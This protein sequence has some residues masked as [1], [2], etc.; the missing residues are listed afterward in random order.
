MSAELEAL[1]KRLEAVAEKL[2]KAGVAVPAG[3]DEETEE[4]PEIIAYDQ[5]FKPKVQQMEA[6]AKAIDPEV[7]EMT[8]F[9]ADCFTEVRRII[10]TGSRFNKPD[11]LSVVMKP[12][13]DVKNAGAKWI[14]DHY[15]TKFVNHSKAVNEGLTV[16]DWVA[17]GPSAGTFVTEMTGA[18][19]CY[20]NKIAM[21]FRGKDENQ[22]KWVQGFV[23]ALKAFPEYINDYHKNGLKWNARAAKA[24]APANM[25][26]AAPAAAPAAKPAPAQAAKPAAAPAKGG[27]AAKFGGLKIP[28]KAPAKEP[29]CCLARDGLYT[30]EYFDGKNP[31]LP[32]DVT[33]K[34][35][36]NF[37]QCKNC[38]LSVP[39]KVKGVAFQNCEKVTII[40]NDVIGT[41]EITNCK[42]TNVFANGICKTI[43]IDK[44]DGI[45]INLSEKS[46][47]CQI[48]TSLSQ[49][50]NVEV[51]DLNEE[52]NMIEFPVPEQI[53][54]HLKDRK[55]VHEVYVHE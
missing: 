30:V 51:P 29:K 49:G 18:V 19:E 53:R 41:C 5:I 23:G 27:L 13:I 25:K 37:Y 11:D 28:A 10:L 1:V 50:L 44:C 26:G 24:T 43:T 46:I 3:G 7:V 55:L 21:E 17:V 14:H 12:L 6:A 4:Y 35:I 40:V 36:V 52:G 32:K 47:E 38:V 33:L 22:M 2:E 48:T 9:I 42:R 45:Q 8:K 54:V 16:F 39:M 34:D 20:T 15:R 31:E